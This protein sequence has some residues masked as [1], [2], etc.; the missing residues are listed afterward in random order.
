M[1]PNVLAIGYPANLA[2]EYQLE[3]M[4][5]V[6]THALHKH[7]IPTIMITLCCIVLLL[8]SSF[9]GRKFWDFS[10]LCSQ[11]RYRYCETKNT[12]FVLTRDP[13]INELS[14]SHL[15]CVCSPTQMMN[16]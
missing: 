11:L 8:S 15:V 1:P 5:T 4:Y 10:L 16:E 3:A 7:C 13:R 14:D 2:F 12:K 9:P 6:R